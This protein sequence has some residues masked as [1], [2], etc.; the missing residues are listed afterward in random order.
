MLK[1]ERSCYNCVLI[2]HP[3]NRPVVAVRAKLRL[4]NK[5]GAEAPDCFY[6][7]HDL[8]LAE[9]I[10]LTLASARGF[11][12]NAMYNRIHT[13]TPSVSNCS[14]IILALLIINYIYKLF[15][16]LFEW[17]FIWLF[18]IRN[19]IVSSRFWR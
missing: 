5:F 1:T 19:Y 11:K 4:N 6:F 7:R 12:L 17:L 13:L 9:L 10:C 18:I 15:I 2:V 16:K 3:N 14:S 8:P